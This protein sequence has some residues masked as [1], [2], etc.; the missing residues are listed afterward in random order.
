MLSTSPVIPVEPSSRRSEHTICRTC[1]VQ[2]SLI[3]EMEGKRPV[4]VVGD[5]NNPV[6]FGFSC[7]K[8]R[9]MAACH[10]L[11]SRLLTPVKRIDQKFESVS[12][13]KAIEEI[14]TKLKKIIAEHGPRSVAV[15]SGTFGSCNTFSNIFA[16]WFMEAIGSK[17]FFTSLTIDQPG[18]LI[19]NA[20]LGPWMANWQRGLE[21]IE[22][23]ILIG[24][25]PI[26]S[27]GGGF[28]FAPAHNIVQGKKRGMKLIVIDPRKTETAHYADLHLQSRPG[29]DP[30]ILAGIIRV[31][32]KEELY[33]KDFVS[34]DTTGIEKLRETVERFTPEMV[35]ECAGIPA[36]SVTEAAHLY[37]AAKK[38]FII[39]GTGANMSPH[40]TL[41]EYL[42]RVLV[43]LCGHWPR[44]GEEI[45]NPGVLMHPTGP[46]VAATPG[47]MPGWGFGEK[48]R[49]HGLTEC[50]AGIP[51]AALSD[52]ILTPGEGQ[53]KAL[54]VIG[55][56][57][58]LAFPDQHKTL[59]AMKA[60]ELLVCLDPV[61]SATAKFAHYVIA[62]TL[63][64]EAPAVS[65]FY[66]QAASWGLH[67]SYAV[68]YAQYT[69]ALIPHP[70]GSDLLD[71]WDFFFR[72]TREMG[73]QI[74]F[75][76]FS[77]PNPKE[78]AAH[79]YPLDM[80]RNYTHD[81]MMEMA[82]EGSPVPLKEI[83]A[84]GRKGHV[85]DL[86]K[87]KVQPKP[88]GWTGKFDIANEAMM[89]ELY[90][91]SIISFRRVNS[92]YPF[93]LI[94]RRMRD[95]YNTNWRELDVLKKK[96]PSNP[97]FMN[98]EDMKA[99]GLATGD[100]VEISSDTGTIY[101]LVAEA[102]DIRRGCVSMSHG[103]G[104]NPG[105]KEDPEK[106]GG[107]TSRLTSTDRDCDPHSWMARQSAI[108][109]RIVNKQERIPTKSA[110]PQME[111]V[112]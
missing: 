51:T 65:S 102:E 110:K 89:H 99:L 37:A 62:P 41:T 14:A 100:V 54:I 104:V 58:M 55:G 66:E 5:K 11:S 42:G 49:V 92:Q 27:I 19:A 45:G 79:S 28:D 103:W 4:K 9:N 91:I 94:S 57:P 64:L 74:T 31:I 63:P 3:V 10:E 69:P 101:G 34:G 90:D 40:G 20:L 23:A 8:G 2:C 17:M 47:P 32:L 68:P 7:I 86:P 96:H 85:F 72:L 22:T 112:D 53:V 33:D 18:K 25:N 105:E 61:V 52:E 76:P 109:V 77:Y 78:A 75:R 12:S 106:Y 50:A 24:Q 82:F 35:A 30:A 88:E 80:S 38:G 60:L 67:W 70:E 59:K 16:S 95:C 87:P 84:K 83:I 71:E 39:C 1:H 108:P 93:L 21:E 44:A 107:C 36:E 46:F 13:Q 29:E 81:Q 111:S 97:A 73:K 98:P 43:T 15:F 48:L 26:I 6:S 56:N